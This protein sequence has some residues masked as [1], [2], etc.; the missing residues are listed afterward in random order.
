MGS[1]DKASDTTAPLTRNGDNTRINYNLSRSREGFLYRGSTLWYLLPD[2]L[3]Q[4]ERISSFKRKVKVWIKQ[5]IPA[6]PR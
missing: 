2:S 4:E 3:Q 5:E 1:F 6:L